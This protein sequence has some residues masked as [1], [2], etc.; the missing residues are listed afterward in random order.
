MTPSSN[1]TLEDI[2]HRILV[3]ED[4]YERVLVLRDRKRRKQRIAAGVVGLALF[5]AAIWVVTS[6]GS[7]DRTQ[8][9]VGPAGSGTSGP[10]VTRPAETGPVETGQNDAGWDGVGIPPEGTPTSTPVK[11]KLIADYSEWRVGFV[12]VYADG[13]VIS[14]PS[15]VL[16]G[17]GHT[18]VERHLTPEGVELV[19]SGAVKASDLLSRYGPVPADAWEDAE[20]RPYAPARYAV[21]FWQDSGDANPGTVNGGY[22]HPPTVLRFLPER[23]R[24]IL[25]GKE[26]T[27]GSGE[28]PRECSEVT[29]DEIRDLS[30]IFYGLRIEDA[31]GDRIYWEDHELL[32]HGG[33]VPKVDG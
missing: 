22:E 26:H 25:T 23:A 6:V 33:F 8:T 2:A 28:D 20:G 18:I 19:R 17:D 1:Q 11:G 13:R 12:F 10:T 30:G 27:Y 16:Y 32:P 29:T 7:F 3:P 5:A 14:D 15:W 31:E 9:Q 21:C 24:E 4:V